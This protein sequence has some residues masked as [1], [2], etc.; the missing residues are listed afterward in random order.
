VNAAPE[1]Q[2]RLLDVQELD[3]TLDRLEHRRVTLP[4][5]AEI[6]ALTERNDSLASDIVRAQTE[7]SD[8]SREQA[9]VD[10]D[11]EQVRNRM[12]RDQQRLDSGQVG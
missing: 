12:Q 1:D 6:E 10:A 11:V 8:L 7:D 5:L 9:K 3:S 4:E 2:L